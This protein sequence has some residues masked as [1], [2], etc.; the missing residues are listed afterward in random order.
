[1]IFPYYGAYRGVLSFILH[2]LFVY[3]AWLWFTSV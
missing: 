3:I 1:M 2:T